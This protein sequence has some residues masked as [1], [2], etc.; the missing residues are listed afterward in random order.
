MMDEIQGI[1][2]LGYSFKILFDSNFFFLFYFNF[3]SF[4]IT[5]NNERIIQV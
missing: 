2:F 4:A 3:K 5:R 1:Y